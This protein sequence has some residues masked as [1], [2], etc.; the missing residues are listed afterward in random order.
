MSIKVPPSRR[1]HPKPH[2]PETVVCE[3]VVYTGRS[4]KL[5]RERVAADL[6]LS[7]LSI[8]CQPKNNQITSLQ[9][10]VDQELHQD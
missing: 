7:G 10:H 2:N 9:F 6:G 8:I 5:K 4:T 1:P 3:D